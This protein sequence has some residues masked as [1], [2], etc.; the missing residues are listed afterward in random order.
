MDRNLIITS[1]QNGE[2]ISI[3][4]GGFPLEE[5]DGCQLALSLARSAAEFLADRLIELKVQAATA[6]AE[7]AAHD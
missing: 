2:T 3:D 5:V 1:R 7:D 4:A 6:E